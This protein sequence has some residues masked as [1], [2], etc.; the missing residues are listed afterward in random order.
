VTDGTS[1]RG[2]T[3]NGSTDQPT[4]PR[5]V[6]ANPGLVARNIGKRFKMRPVLRDVSLEV[7]RGEAVGL[8]GPNGAGK[9]TSFYVITGLISAD[10]GSILLDGADI[11]DLP[12]YRRARLG[13]G[14]LPQEASIFRGLTVEQNVRAILEVVDQ[15]FASYPGTGAFGRGTP[16]S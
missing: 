14:Y 2:G 15:P 10:Y 5:L 9:T 8:L 11:S 1:S 13:I 3:M 12:M 7:Q 4:T 16:T 6:S